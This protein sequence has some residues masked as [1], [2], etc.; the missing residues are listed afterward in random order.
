MEMS[1]RD[2]RIRAVFD[3][4][5]S[6][7]TR[8]GLEIKTYATVDNEDLDCIFDDSVKCYISDDKKY[9]CYKI[10]IY[11]NGINDTTM[12]A[13][14]MRGI[15]DTNRYSFDYIDNLLEIY[16]FDNGITVYLRGNNNGQT[17]K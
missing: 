15:Y 12:R 1:L 10:S 14:K 17:N 9:N 13:L 3:F 8:E 2:K 11:W 16:D 4:L 7:N 6:F 5:H